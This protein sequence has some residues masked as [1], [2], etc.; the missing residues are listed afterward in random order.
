MSALLACNVGI[1]ITGWLDF[2]LDGS[3]LIAYSGQFESCRATANPLSVYQCCRGTAV[4]RGRANGSVGLYVAVVVGWT[5]ISFQGFWLRIVHFR[6]FVWMCH[7]LRDER[8]LRGT[9]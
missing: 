9:L 6:I 3:F 8:S 4:S 5:E 7:N 2:V 1:D